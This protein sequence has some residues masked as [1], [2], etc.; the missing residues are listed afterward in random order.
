MSQSASIDTGQILKDIQKRDEE[1]FAIPEAAEDEEFGG[2]DSHIYL[3]RV[4]VSNDTS[5]RKDGSI[6]Y[7]L[8]GYDKLGYFEG[9]KKRY[10]NFFVLHELFLQRY[11]GLYVPILPPKKT[12]NNKNMAFV[13]ERRHLLQ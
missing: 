10:Q 2:T 5:N 6:L 7:T 13:E 9:V 1:S 8:S 3:Q 12:F 11:R 4:K